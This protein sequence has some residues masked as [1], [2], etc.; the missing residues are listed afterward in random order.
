MGLSIFLLIFGFF[1]LYLGAEGLV[2]GSSKTARIFGIRPV[3]IGATI[4]AYGT[5]MPEFVVSVVASAKGTSDIALGN[6]I[7]S[8]I[9][10]IAL[11]LGL[12]TIFTRLIVDPLLIRREL[13]FMLGGTV[14]IC[15]MSLNGTIGRID[16][17]ILWAALIAFSYVMIVKIKKE[18]KA[19]NLERI[20]KQME[21]PEK[22]FKLILI[23]AVLIIF[24]SIGLVSGA[25]Y[26]VSAVIYFGNYFNI[27]PRI[28]GITVVATGT[29]L[30][31]LAASIVS[32]F[33]K[34]ADLC[35]GNIIGSNIFNIMMVVSTAGLVR[36]FPV[37]VQNLWVEYFFLLA[38]SFALYPILKSK[39][40]I[41]TLYGVLFV[42]GYPVFVLMLFLK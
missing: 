40:Y 10:N 29:S 36:P 21:K 33:H 5:S 22:N 13:P 7:G 31:E 3:I 27:S 12:S 30:P 37:N 18:R 9:F 1:A 16:G 26:L 38:Y 41:P 25:E 4:V 15:L 23:N 32:A 20:E 8:N 2:R 11:V 34:E 42:L 24:G 17:I 35:I 39:N 19:A 6:V 28:I 14:A